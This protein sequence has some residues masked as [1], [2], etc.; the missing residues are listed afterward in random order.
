MSA[1]FYATCPKGLE[2]LLA[3]E[4]QQIGASA[5]RVSGSGVEFDGSLPTAFAACLWS[6][7]ANK[8]LLPLG[9]W[10]VEDEQ[11]LYE[12]AGAVN[13][14]EHLAPAGSFVVDFLGTN[15][16][17][18]HSQY[19]ALRIKDAVV[20]QLRRT[21]GQRPNIDKSNPDLRINALLHRGRVQ[22]SLDLSGR[23]LHR[24]GYRTEQ[25]AAPLK[26]NLAAAILL[27]SGWREMAASG[28]ALLDPMC[29]SGTFLVEAAWMAADV[30]PGLLQPRFGFDGWLQHLPEQWEELLGEARAR[31]E[32]GLARGL[33]EIRGYDSNSVVL[34]AAQNN[35]ERAGVEQW[36]RVSCK[37]LVEFKRPTHKTLERGLV[38]CNPP[39]GERLGEE[40]ELRATY[41]TLG[42]VAKAE[43]PGWQL[44]IF[45]GN[46]ELARE[47]RLRPKQKYKLFNGP[48]AAQLLLFDLLSAAQARLRE[49]DDEAADTGDAAQVPSLGS[50]TAGA[51]MLVNRLQKNRKRL[52]KWLKKEGVNCYRLYDADM[53]EYAAAVDVYGERL[54]VQEYA[55]PKT[56]DPDAAQR[57]WKDVLEATAFVFGC[58]VDAIAT[59]TRQ[60]NRGAQQYQK[61]G[62][63]E[64]EHFFPVREGRAELLVNLQDYLDTGLFLD[65]RPLRLRLGRETAGKRFLNLFCYTA[66]ATVHAALGGAQESISVDL[67]NTYLEWAE[68]NFARNQINPA[69]HQLVQQDCQQ[70]L[71]ECRQGFD[72]I[73]LDPPTFSN[74]KRMQGVFDVQR[75]HV[76]TI[77]RCMELLL[78]GGVLYFSTNLR[79]F[80]LDGA[81][82]ARW[83]VRNITRETLDADFAQNAK[84]HQCYAIQHMRDSSD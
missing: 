44:A 30:A 53:P 79:S 84:I 72:I 33:P 48:I 13:W 9:S 65:H 1:Q 74:S 21:H 71:R 47:T 43:L 2:T 10:A 62:Q 58:P 16:Q 6:R 64:T 32:A 12:V 50:L 51:Q 18:R 4:L 42:E 52:A 15:H 19:G 26:E 8:I 63:A 45:T 59:K 75:D 77:N 7:L 22:L 70:W 5:T 56:V 34:K 80:K 23:S 41:R 29:G 78:P 3:E 83:D 66:T 49:G 46:P 38:V 28:G 73:M 40:A 67:S 57:R 81:A 61:L 35:I 76:A 20:D 82:L 69:H 39:Y 25:G 60:R 54:H 36:V 17:I 68:R 27:R 11:S 14:S 55:A 37:P 31:R 24:R